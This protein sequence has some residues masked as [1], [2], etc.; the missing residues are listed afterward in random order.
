MRQT[1]RRTISRTII[2]MFYV[3]HM[4]ALQIVYTNKMLFE[5]IGISN[6]INLMIKSYEIFAGYSCCKFRTTPTKMGGYNSS[7]KYTA[8]F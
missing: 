1:A 4:R 8:L 6:M 2:T 3:R 5:R 7:V